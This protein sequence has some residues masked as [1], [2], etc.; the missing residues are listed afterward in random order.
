MRVFKRALVSAWDKTGIVELC[1]ILHNN[2]IEI[3]STGGTAAILR[4][5]NIPVI[6]VS[7][8]TGFPE[9]LNGRVKTL[10]PKIHGAILADR[11]KEEHL[12]ELS[13][14]SIVPIDI[15]ICNLYPFEKVTASPGVTIAEAVEHIDI[16]GV[17]LLRAAA[18][19]HKDIVIL[20][21]SSDYD[22]LLQALANSKDVSQQDR[23]K[24]ASKAFKRTASYDSAI[25][26][27]FSN[28]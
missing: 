19:N 9:I 23:V 20:Y 5:N 24:L 18:K 7:D 2:G 12:S 15:V 10:H 27:Y 17:T 22:V 11:S 25:E 16:G 6:K 13:K 26:S 21:D 14:H 1:K 28:L 8:C 3:V 4:E